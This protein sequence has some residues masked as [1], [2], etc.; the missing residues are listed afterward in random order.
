MERPGVRQSIAGARL[1][2]R[3]LGIEMRPGADRPVARL[4]FARDMLPSILP[5]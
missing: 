5:R 3:G 2:E 4:N 1:R